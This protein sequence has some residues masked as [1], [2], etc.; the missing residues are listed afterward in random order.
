MR[1]RAARISAYQDYS[2]MLE[3]TSRQ[4]WTATYS[5]AGL[6]SLARPSRYSLQNRTRLQVTKCLARPKGKWLGLEYGS[7]SFYC[8]LRII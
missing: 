7:I 3:L 2:L 4:D 5:L 6:V 8:S 1:M